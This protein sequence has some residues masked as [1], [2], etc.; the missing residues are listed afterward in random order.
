M[1]TFLPFNQLV[2]Q[3]G[4]TILETE[5]RNTGL[6]PGRAAIHHPGAL[7]PGAPSPGALD[8]GALEETEPADGRSTFQTLGGVTQ[9]LA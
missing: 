3:L 8:P 7:G 2:Y 4:F 9:G 5:M 6:T 1:V